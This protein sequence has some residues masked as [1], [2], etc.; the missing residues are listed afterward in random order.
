MNVAEHNRRAWNRQAREGCRWSTPAG[1]T[2]IAEAR[3]G[4][5]RILLTP[6]TPVPQDWLGDLRGQDVLCLASGG[7]QQA[8]LLA[9]AGARVTSFDLSEEQLA[10]DRTV[11][12]RE[13]L[14]L[15]TVQGDMRDLS[16]FG[17]ATF[18]RIVHVTSNVFCP[19]VRPVWKE[20]FRVLRPGGEL[21]AG[22]MN[23]AY[24]LFDHD[25]VD[26]GE[27]P[28]VCYSL[29]FSDPSDLPPDRLRRLIADGEALEFSHSL[30]AQIGGQLEAG[31]H[32]VGFFE[33][34]WSEVPA[35]SGRFPP[36][37][38]TRA[39]KPRPAEAPAATRGSHRG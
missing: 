2:E 38:N 34:S 31:F 6:D 14:E 29:P 25:A 16:D 13:A 39:R 32:L 30:D 15:R 10:L 37:L 27:P 17:D 12:G 22:F 23:P 19:E 8:P 36:L 1:P 33:D 18:D 5:P 21:L 4:A 3:G 20:C 9:A 7:G 26:R 24:F 28:V 11:A 35:I